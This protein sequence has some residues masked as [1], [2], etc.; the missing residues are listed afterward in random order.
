MTFARQPI[1]I[2]ETTGFFVRLS[3]R[4]N[5]RAEAKRIADFKKAEEAVASP[6][7]D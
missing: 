4:A 6:P 7:E 2:K 5:K 3:D 1:Y